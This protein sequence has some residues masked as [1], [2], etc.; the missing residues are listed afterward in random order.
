MTLVFS[1]CA[2]LLG[3]FALGL[4]GSPAKAYITFPVTTL[5]QLCD[6]STYVTLVRVEK[7]SQEN[8]IIVY[9]K[10]RDLKGEYPKD[11]IKHIFDLKN[12][13]AHKGPGDVP[14][15]PDEKDWHYAAKWPE[16]GKTA[17][18]FARKYDRYGDF[19]HSY[20]DGC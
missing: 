18:L 4:F 12:T 9:K 8:G 1:R 20:I 17:I 3:T 16:V 11:K 7:F 5:G 6:S 19:G 13:P 10:V 15:R 2:S 14:I